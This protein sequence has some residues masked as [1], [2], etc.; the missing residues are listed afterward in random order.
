MSIAKTRRRT[1]QAARLMGDFQ[2]ARSGRIW[3][4]LF[5][6]LAG[7]MAAKAMRSVWR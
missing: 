7:R 3:Q 2:A 5:N 4:R 1:Y 6:R